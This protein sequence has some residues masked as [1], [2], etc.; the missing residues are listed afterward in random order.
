MFSVEI[1]RK[2]CLKKWNQL[3]WDFGQF[4]KKNPGET[5]FFRTS[6][7]FGIAKNFQGWCFGFGV[8]NPSG[9]NYKDQNVE[10][11]C[12]KR[13]ML[14]TCQVQHK[15]WKKWDFLYK[16]RSNINER[17]I[18]MWLQIVC[19]C[20][21]FL[22]VNWLNVS[23]SESFLSSIMI[24][25]PMKE[26]FL[27]SLIQSSQKTIEVSV[28]QHFPYR[29]K[30]HTAYILSQSVKSVRGIFH[31]TVQARIKIRSYLIVGL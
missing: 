1:S 24:L 11:Y 14:A 12:H 5:I 16:C 4:Q 9:R 18:R 29:K 26:S 23:P 7:G 20:S 13:F 31:K 17:T 19:F 25:F 28:Q 22:S 10:M 21:Y 15:K 30:W 8:C 6:W 27:M 2:F 3:T